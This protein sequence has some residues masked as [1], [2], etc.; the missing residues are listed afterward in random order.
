MY[1]ILDKWYPNSKFILTIR[2]NTFDAVNSQMKMILREDNN[3]NL[4][5]KQITN[6]NKDVKS[7]LMTIQ[8]IIMLDAR[9]YDIHLQNV[10]KYFKHKKHQLLTL[11]LW[12]SDSNTIWNDISAFLGCKSIPN[13]TFP[14]ENK[15]PKIQPKIILPN[16]TNLNWH[17]YKFKRKYHRFWEYIHQRSTNAD[18]D[19]FL[20]GLTKFYTPKSAN[21]KKFKLRSKKKI[22]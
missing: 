1:P 11:N 12:K 21:K 4:G 18:N 3:V 2:N 8:Q 9:R 16:D 10:N 22:P 5:Y 15:A 14:H 6:I 19:E 7:Y 17:R 20:Q 13:I